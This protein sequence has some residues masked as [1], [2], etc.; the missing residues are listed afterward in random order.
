MVQNTA[1]RLHKH[2]NSIEP[3][4]QFTVEASRPARSMSFLD[5][6]LMPGPGGSLATT[7]YRK[8]M[9]IDGYFQRDYYHYITTKY[10]VIN[11]LVHKA[12]T[13][14]STLQLLAKEE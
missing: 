2:I 6:L 4:I 10:S 8:L 13:V 3:H 9:H 1:E 11:T 12:K 5:T 7:V 14:C